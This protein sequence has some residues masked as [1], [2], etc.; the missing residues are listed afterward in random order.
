MDDQDG[1]AGSQHGGERGRADRLPLVARRGRLPP[2]I[3][4][5]A[6]E[7]EPPPWSVALDRDGLAWQHMGGRRAGAKPDQYWWETPLYRGGLGWDGLNERRGPLRVIHQP[8][9]GDP[10]PDRLP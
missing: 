10:T 2:T 9:D 7:L 6:D 5:M 1:D 3:G 4:R 8:G